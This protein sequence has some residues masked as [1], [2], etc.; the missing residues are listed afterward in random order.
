MTEPPAAGKAQ[1]APYCQKRDHLPVYGQ[2]KGFSRAPA[3]AGAIDPNL[4]GSCYN[5]KEFELKT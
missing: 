1:I 5:A 2:R 4:A 3:F